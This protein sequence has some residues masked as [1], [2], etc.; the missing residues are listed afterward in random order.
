MLVSIIFVGKFIG[1]FVTH[2]LAL[3]SDSWHLLTDI[4]SL[5]ISWWGLKISTKRANNKYTFGYYRF[6]ILT[7]LINNVSLIIISLFIFYQAILRYLHPVDIQ[8]DGM[9]IFAILGLIVNTI[10]V[11]NLKDDSDNMNVKSVF[12][13]FIGDALSDTGVLLGGIIIYFTRL[14]GVDT[15]LSAI[16]ACLILKNAVM[17]TFECV[18]IL[19]EAAPENIS[20]NDVRK[21]IKNIENIEEVTDMHIWSLSKEVLA[22][23]AHVSVKHQD[24]ITCE[25]TLHKI[26]HLLKDEFNIDHSTIQFE[27]FTCSSCFH[28]KAD[29]QN[30]CMMCI[31]KC[32]K[33]REKDSL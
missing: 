25:E 8:P 33:F 2:S 20:I 6:G 30:G 29:H 28:S 21:S 15:L 9:I 24:V 32:E 16:L 19:L 5:I 4:A 22:I 12:L 11:T 10:I 3:F 23:T 17:M 31:D 13:H 27:H 18:K 7:A 1:A 14:S 26:Q